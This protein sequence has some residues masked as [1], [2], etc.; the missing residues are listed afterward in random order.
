MGIT[1]PRDP[2]RLLMRTKRPSVSATTK[3]NPHQYFASHLRTRRYVI[4]I[5]QNEWAWQRFHRN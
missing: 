4:K 1:L 2:Y 5:H 3:T